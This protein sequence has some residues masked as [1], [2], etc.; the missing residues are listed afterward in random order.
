MASPSSWEDDIY[1]GEAGAEFDRGSSRFAHIL[2]F[3]AIAFFVV[4]GTWASLATLDEVTRG[5]GKVIPSGQVQKVQNLEGGIVAE[6]AI[7][8]GQVVQKGELLLRIENT[9]AAAGL[10]ERRGRYLALLASVTRLK[11]EAEGHDHFE[12]PQEVVTEAPRIAQNETLLFQ[13]RQR[14]MN[15]QI[16]ILDSQ[17]DQKQQELIELR[18]RVGQL[19]KTRQLAQQELDLLRPLVLQGIS[20]RLDQLRVEQKMQDLDTELQGIRLAIPRT[21]SSVREAQNR[22]Q[23]KRATVRS[24]AQTELNAKRVE[25]DSITEELTTEA[26]RVT[27]TEVRSP[28]HGAVKALLVNTIGGVVQPGQDLVEIVPLEDKLLIEARIRPADRAQLRPGLQATVKVTAYDFSIF[29]GLDATLIDISP[30]T[31]TDEEGNAF[32]RIRLRTESNSLGPE[33]P[34][35]PGVTATVDILTGEKTVLD[36]LMKPIIKARDTA[37]RER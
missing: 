10:R 7:Q 18:A 25:L 22:I 5:D 28:V 31:I 6:L 17:A 33:R 37:L 14:Q 2:L 9:V 16:Q 21:E 24:E 35:V 36:Y 11:A 19:E 23:E 29:G 4:L 20:P 26:D 34:I 8:E 12:V 32:Y 15:E 13:A 3:T 30:D 27:R 1:A